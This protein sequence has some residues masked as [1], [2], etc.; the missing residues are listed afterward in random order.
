MVT[1]LQTGEN[2]QP[3]HSYL[4]GPRNHLRS[5]MKAVRSQTIDL[6]EESRYFDDDDEENELRA[7]QTASGSSKRPTSS[8]SCEALKHAV[9][10]LTRLDDFICEKIGKG[11]FSEV[12]RVAHRTTGKVMV[13]KMNT[14][15]SNRP[16]MLREV[17][18]MNRLNHPNILRFM[19]VCV[20]EGQLH[21]LTEY[22]NGGALY[23]V[24]A[25]KDIELPWKTRIN[26]AL[27][28]SNGMR[29]FHTRGVFHRDLTSK[30]IL[31]K[32]SEDDVYTA[33]VADFG[34]AAKIPDPLEEFRLSIVGSPYWMAPEVLKGKKYNEKAD[35]FSFGIILCEITARIDADP[36][37]LPRTENFGLDYIAFSEMV[38][39]C[40]L[41]FLHLAFR[42][43]QI[44][45]LKR[46]T[47]ANNV[48]CL[49]QMRH[50]LDNPGN[51]GKDLK[52]SK[53][54][55]KRSR[56]EDNILDSC[57]WSSM[58]DDPTMT[59]KVIGQT[60]SEADPFYVPGRSNPFT[61]LNKFCDGRKVLG[62]HRDMNLSF[63]LPSPSSPFTPPC[64]PITPDHYP[65][66]KRPVGRRKCQSLPGSP[67]LLRQAA[68]R[69]HQESIHGSTSQ[70]RNIDFSLDILSNLGEFFCNSHRNRFTANKDGP[71]APDQSAKE[72]IIKPNT[73]TQSPQSRVASRRKAFRAKQH[74]VESSLLFTSLCN[75]KPLPTTVSLDRADTKSP[76]YSPD[77]F[78]NFSPLHSPQDSFDTCITSSESL[79]HITE[80]RTN[81]TSPLCRHEYL[82]NTSQSSTESTSSVITLKENTSYIAMNVKSPGK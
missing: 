64:T 28:I 59:A 31:I 21:A 1:S 42:C 53:T 12:Y 13:L 78:E 54:S 36:D 10:A 72:N 76:G 35:V 62:A 48:E 41:D 29:Y 19:G 50:F 5:S 9:S 74:S 81:D 17:Q 27:D 79:P 61:L 69:F 22:I 14:C 52:N 77:S 45:P 23:Q 67:V 2:G 51:S 6:G 73:L 63:D 39:Y 32:I 18:L 65:R 80:S 33:I 57:N 37:I 3:F 43:C 58:D 47:F 34:L 44:D 25:N 11:F 30:N 71:Q 8:N 4:D 55:C 38:E 40:P 24:L 7:Y 49:L 26:L 56:S 68:E 16:N 82:Y 15:S 46:P 66:S 75:E 70:Q 20:H 60:M